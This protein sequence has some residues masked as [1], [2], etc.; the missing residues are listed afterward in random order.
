[1]KNFADRLIRAIH[2]KGN[3]CV[4]GLDPRI[5][6]MPDCIVKALNQYSQEEAIY[7]AITVFH[8]L[9][10]DCVSPYIP[11][12]KLQI[13]FYE[14][15]GIAGLKAFESTIRYAQE[16]ELLVIADAKRNDISSTAQAYAN[17][18]LGKTDIFGALTPIFDADCIT[19]SPFL[20]KDSLEPFVRTCIDE[21]KGAFVLVK[22]SN[23][24]SGDFQ[25]VRLD[26]GEIMYERLA[27]YVHE[28]G[29][30]CIGQF[31][32]SSIGAVVGATFPQQ[33]SQLRERMPQSIFLVPGYGAQGG[34]G[35]DV[36]PCFNQD[37][38]GAV[39]NASRSITYAHDDA[40]IS[41][42]A[43]QSLVYSQMANMVSD[44][45][46]AVNGIQK[47]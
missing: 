41:R 24:G 47:L 39:V 40:S 31:G 12:V 33:A 14:Q 2:T 1:M 28:A 8:R 27:R 25:D 45:T 18:F 46:S 7:R 34:D 4:V 15:Y 30:E 17:A 26:S 9:I 3:P 5:D 38:L 44:V 29:A 43:F 36:V 13:A 21:G 22:T 32:Y 10:I 16:Q 6:Q 20:G 19:I 35:R 37:G 42:E 11:A 23:S